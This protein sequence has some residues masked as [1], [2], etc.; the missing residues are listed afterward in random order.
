MKAD[1][2]NQMQA[3]GFCFL[4]MSWGSLHAVLS[5]CNFCRTVK[6]C[7]L[8][9]FNKYQ[10]WIM[11]RGDVHLLDLISRPAHIFLEWSCKTP[12]STAWNKRA[13]QSRKRMPLQKHFFPITRARPLFAADTAWLFH[14]Q[15]NR[16]A[17]TISCLACSC[18]W[19]D[20]SL[21]TRLTMKKCQYFLQ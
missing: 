17:L 20:S 21:K 5:Y 19:Q 2:F 14:W 15:I 1:R 18:S 6:T 11:M 8:Y 16:C 3:P 7:F 12:W 10:F 13:F 4:Y 9:W